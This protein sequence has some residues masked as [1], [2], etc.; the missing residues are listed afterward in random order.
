MSFPHLWLT[1]CLGQLCLCTFLHIFAIDTFGDKSQL[2][3]MFRNDLWGSVVE[4]ER[5]R[6]IVLSV[7][8]AAY[9][10]DNVSLLSDGVFDALA[11]KSDKTINTGRFDDFWKEHF[12]PSTGQWV[13]RHP[14][15]EGLRKLSSH[16]IRTG[17]AM[18]ATAE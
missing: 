9:E 10:F 12:D 8:A 6:R 18:S 16:F 13:H 2:A 4:V 14:D 7:A 15:L 5:R 1:R 17:V 3:G 11:R